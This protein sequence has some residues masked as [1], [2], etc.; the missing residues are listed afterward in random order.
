MTAMQDP[1]SRSTLHDGYGGISMP[2]ISMLW[3]LKQ[4]DLG[5]KA[6]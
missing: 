1:G 3:R 6:L 2:V 4:E 5:F